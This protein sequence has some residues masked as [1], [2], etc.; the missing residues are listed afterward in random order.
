MI[1]HERNDPMKTLRS[2]K[3]NTFLLL[4]GIYACSV[5]V[6]FFLATLTSFF[7]TVY[8]DEFLY[9]SLGRSIATEGALL[10]HGQPALYNYLA[11]PLLISPVYK[12]FPAGTD[13]YRMLQLW[14]F[15]IMCLSV[16]PLYALCRAMLKDEKKALKLAALFMLLPDFILGQ[17]ILSEA[18]IYPLFFTLLVLV[19]RS[20][21]EGLSLRDGIGIGVIGGVLYQT[22][23]GD[24]VLPAMA[25]LFFLIRGIVQKE[26][27]PLLYTLAGAV[28]LCMVY[29]AF[30]LIADRALAYSG[31][32]FSIYDH[33]MNDFN[34]L[35]Y[36]T[37]LRS[38][39]LYPYYFILSCGVL[40]IMWGAARF[41]SLRRKDMHFYL[42]MLSS[43]LVMIVGIAWFIN[44]P[45]KSNIL[46]L[47]YIAMY[48][49]LSL[50]VC[51]LP[52]RT[53]RAPSPAGHPSWP[54]LLVTAGIAGYIAACAM[55]FGSRA[56]ATSYLHSPF[57]ASMSMVLVRNTPG[58]A[59]IVFALVCCVSLYITL[60]GGESKKMAALCCGV[61]LA[62]TLTNNVTAYYINQLNTTK[63]RSE[64]TLAIQK[65]LKGEPYIYVYADV[66][67]D[68]G[69]D[70]NTNQ[71]I[72]Q[73][74]LYDFFNNIRKN[75][76]AYKPFVPKSEK[77]MVAS[78]VM[79]DPGLLVL[80]EYVHPLIK[81]N[82]AA[83][84]ASSSDGNYLMVR[85]TPGER[86]VDSIIG[87]VEN[88]KL[89]KSDTGIL[90]LFNEAWLSGPITVT[91]EIESEE[92]QTLKLFN[93]RQF[94]LPLLSGRNRYAITI[95]K[96]EYAYNFTVDKADIT[97]HQYGIS[98]AD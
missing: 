35:Y 97:I 39:L 65:A 59:A 58:I 3:R 72:S 51:L 68:M 14:N 80:D 13:Y 32:F 20:V 29:L 8:V 81:F 60:R 53:D 77:G 10:Y 69:M 26:K 85:Y 27:K 55:I 41:S 56:G 22:K 25:L 42:L 12:L 50:L 71:N 43:L 30:R 91:M 54:R 75:G 19:Y 78:R 93:S 79:P 61:F 23:P 94:E 64:E 34:G 2:K 62:V 24:V 57:L 48:M 96:P 88:M 38:V 90:I 28:S 33:Q 83:R 49:P 6:R 37:F 86:I 44:R 18:L 92:E 4:L 15:C 74:A 84:C 7:P 89:N 36:D 17:F 73:V 40:P 98:Q 5:L 76:G 31:S 46:Y 70:V 67:C 16:F 45:E 66:V 1:S 82:S 47:R 11:Y 9:Y 87:N 63:P 52:L 95:N 21:Q